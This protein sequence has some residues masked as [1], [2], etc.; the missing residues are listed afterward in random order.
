MALTEMMRALEEEASVRFELIRRRAVAEA[1]ALLKT[2]EERRS[3]L[4]DEALAGA[5]L[6]LAAEKVRRITRAQFAVRKEV[7]LLKQTLIEQVFSEARARL[8]TVREAETYPE[9]F[10]LLAQ[11][12]LSGVRGPVQVLVH[13][14]DE[15]LAAETLSGVE[16]CE[17]LPSLTTAGGLQVRAA[18]GR[19]FIDN[20]VEARL[21]K[22]ERLLRSGV[23][24]YLFGEERA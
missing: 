7:I 5:R 17:I 24:E 6:D 20:T 15:A 2:A 10:G 18:G 1:Q 8:G 12:A 9:A 13:P 22:A 3:P 23:H 11:E 16:G 19:A 4:R 21:A 14:A